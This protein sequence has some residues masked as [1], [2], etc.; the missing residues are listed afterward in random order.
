MGKGGKTKSSNTSTNTSGQNGIQGDNLGASIAGVN[1]STVNVQS[2]DY[3]AIEK[4]TQLG[5]LAMTTASST[6]NKAMD[7]VS[8]FADKALSKYSASN[9]ESLQTLSGLA[10]NQATQ[11]EQNINAMMKLAQM[12]KDGGQVQTTAEMTKVMLGTSAVIG[13]VVLYL[14]T[15]GR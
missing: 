13:L 4:A 12:N 11:N 8:N 9:S 14:L 15:K 5:E 3:G 6:A 10:G 1:N 2:T 7:N